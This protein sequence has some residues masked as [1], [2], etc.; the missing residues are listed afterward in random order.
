MVVKQILLPGE[1]FLAD[2]RCEGKD[3]ACQSMYTT[4]T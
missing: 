2:Y 3:M 4:I 1:E